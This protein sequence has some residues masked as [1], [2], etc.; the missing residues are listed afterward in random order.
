[1]EKPKTDEPPG[2]GRFFK[3]DVE[4]E[5]GFADVEVVTREDREI[6]LCRDCYDTA[7][8]NM[9]DDGE[10]VDHVFV[11]T[12]YVLGRFPVEDKKLD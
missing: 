2:G 11:R 4:A 9:L 3:C 1:M 12:D 5:H 7:L 8:I 10:W 6:F